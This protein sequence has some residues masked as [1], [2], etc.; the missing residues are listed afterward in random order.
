MSITIRI[1]PE[2]HQKFT[3]STLELSRIQRQVLDQIILDPY[4][5]RDH[6]G[7]Q[8]SISPRTVSNIINQLK[9]LHIIERIGYTK[10]GHWEVNIETS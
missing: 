6:I 8:L 3:S 1:S 5:T 2:I 9:K 4:C 10:G 7:Q